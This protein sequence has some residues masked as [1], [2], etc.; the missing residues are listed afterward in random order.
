MA[1]VIHAF[2]RHPSLLMAASLMLAI[3][4]IVAGLVLTP[5]STSATL[6]LSTVQ[7]RAERGVNVYP[8]LW[9]PTRY[10]GRAFPDPGYPS[11]EAYFPI[12]E[13]DRIK[14]LGFDH[15]RIPLNIGPLLIAN[16]QQRGQRADYIFRQ[17]DAIVAKGLKV[18]V[19]IHTPD[20]H[21]SDSTYDA[22]AIINRPAMF[23]AFNEVLAQ[24][25]ARAG[26]RP[27]DKVALELINE[28]QV[29][30]R[31][32]GLWE[33]YQAGFL[34]IARQHAPLTTIV[35]TGA[36]GGGLFGLL[37]LD[38]STLN[39]PNTLFSFHYY[40]PSEFIYQSHPPK[41]L[42][43]LADYRPRYRWPA[44]K[45]ARAETLAAFTALTRSAPDT[46][47]V[48]AHIREQM[49][50]IQEYYDAGYDAGRIAKDF[51]QALDWAD[52]HGVT[53]DRLLLG[54]FGVQ[55]AE[56]GVLPEY[57]ADK[58]NW[59]KTVRAQAERDGIAWAYWCYRDYF[60]L[61]DIKTGMLDPDMVAAL[62]VTKK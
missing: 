17:V 35:L 48:Q 16:D 51:R 40:L 29:N 38:P 21:R 12:K 27:V 59:L 18:I 54:E 39:D 52:R 46:P 49:R 22:E 60:G 10:D 30:C 31:I 55:R 47:E 7:F 44:T 1:L 24:V 3:L 58:L 37:Q 50:K 36:C 57:D 42:G 25:A 62:G 43:A 32:P 28:P 6:P 56:P 11:V 15:V 33:T 13:F 23:A 14:S 20:P 2:R 4:V 9:F 19:D 61:F 41:A 53:H 26:R 45:S 5:A 34:K 8:F